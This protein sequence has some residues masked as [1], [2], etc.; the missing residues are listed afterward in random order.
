MA[1]PIDLTSLKT[2]VPSVDGK[3]LA[4]KEEEM[5]L[6]DQRAELQAENAERLTWLAR[7]NIAPNPVLELK[8][9]LDTL[10]DLLLPEDG[11]GRL[12]Y[13]LLYEKEYGDLLESILV[14]LGGPRLV[15][16]PQ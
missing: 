8:I 3:D 14:E 2:P 15:T 13:E 5:S 9:R 10:T 4:P 16:P 6:E 12:P 11:K 1:E 7:F